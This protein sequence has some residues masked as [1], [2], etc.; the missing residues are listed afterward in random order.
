MVQ[1]TSRSAL[2]RTPT[3]GSIMC[4]AEQL[5]WV[6]GWLT[7]HIWHDR[8]VH[9]WPLLGSLS[10]LHSSPAGCCGTWVPADDISATQSI[11]QLQC[12]WLKWLHT[13]WQWLGGPNTGHQRELN[14][15]FYVTDV[16]A[17]FVQVLMVEYMYDITTEIS[18]FFTVTLKLADILE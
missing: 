5:S 9:W 16:F 11:D 10:M 4:M 2:A 6:L 7:M 8:K 3:R 14:C 17:W 13:S 15:C 1:I 18:M 12:P